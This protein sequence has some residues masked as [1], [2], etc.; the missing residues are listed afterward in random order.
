MLIHNSD[1]NILSLDDE[2]IDSLC[3]FI[4]NDIKVK[5]HKDNG[6]VFYGGEPT[7]V[8]DTIQKIMDR[9]KPLDVTYTLY[10]NG[11]LL[12]TLPHEILSRLDTVLIAIDGEKEIHETYKPLGSYDKILENVKMLKKYNCQTIGR[13][14]VEEKV[15]IFESVNNIV[16]YFDFIHWG[17]VNKED[18]DDLNGFVER[19]RENIT[20]LYNH[21][22]DNLRN[23]KIINLI[24]FN[25]MILSMLTGEVQK[26]FAC[27]CGHN[28]TTVDLEGN[29]YLCDEFIKCAP[30]SNINEKTNTNIA[31]VDH[32]EIFE[33][34]INCDVTDICL[35]RCRMTLTLYSDSLLRN[36][37]EMTKILI[38]LMQCSLEE[39][40]NII[41]NK[42]I[43]LKEFNR[44]LYTT[45]I[46]P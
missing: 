32:K 8:P 37:C 2:R 12:D 39:I 36:Y 17:L 14:T 11:I 16:D 7:L 4:E 42:N 38:S 27:G 35:G 18:F 31:Y 22:L 9:T 5:N 20:S 28:I 15:N 10:T 3:D 26:S 25:R 13:I 43:S 44:E 46:I 33:D 6:I 40:K 19:Y 24:P 29:I 34:C 1:K 30:Y 45:E 23:G 21:W 41:S